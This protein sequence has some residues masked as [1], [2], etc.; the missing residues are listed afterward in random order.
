L[1]FAFCPDREDARRVS[2][3]LVHSRKGKRGPAYRWVHGRGGSFPV[4]DG[5]EL[6]LKYTRTR[7]T[8]GAQE[9][10]DFL[11]R[12]VFLADSASKRFPECQDFCGC[13]WQLT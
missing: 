1:V 9:F 11:E 6:G 10:V 5:N 4:R 2:L 12:A 13:R 3:A 8:A 7:G